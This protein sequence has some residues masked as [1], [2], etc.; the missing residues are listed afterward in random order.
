MGNTSGT[1]NI[2]WATGACLFVR[3]EA[4]WNIGGFDED[5]FAHQEEIDLCWR[6]QA[7]GGI[8]KYVGASSIYHLGGATLNS[9]DP[10]KTFYNF[11]NSLLLLIKNVKGAGLCWTIFMRLMLDGIAA[12]QFLFQGKIAHTF[13]ILKAHLS[14]YGLLPKFLKKRREQ[15]T[16]LKYFHTKSVVWAYFINKKRTFNEL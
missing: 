15:A 6:L 14:F 11:R 9:E 16:K 2:F 4:F 5:F 12:V 8:I 1:K 13:A 7:H 10:K 3:K